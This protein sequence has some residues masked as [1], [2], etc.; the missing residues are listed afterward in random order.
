MKIKPNVNLA[1]ETMI[2][3]VIYLDIIFLL[4]LFFFIENFKLFSIIIL[5]SNI[6]L[7]LLR[8]GMKKDADKI[9]ARSN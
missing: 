1:C 6:L 9:N 7:L 3:Y 2:K 5:V 4:L 8:Q